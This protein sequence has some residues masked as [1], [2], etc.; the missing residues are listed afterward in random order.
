MRIRLEEYLKR[1]SDRHSKYGSV[2]ALFQNAWCNSPEDF[3]IKHREA[4][5]CKNVSKSLHLWIDLIFGFKQRGEAA[6]SADNVFHHLT[7]EGSVDL[8]AIVDP[9][10]RAS[11]EAQ[12]NEFGQ[13][14]QQLFREP[15][16]PR[17][18]ENSKVGKI[19]S[20]SDSV[21]GDVFQG[22]N[23]KF[24]LQIMAAIPFRTDSEIDVTSF[25]V[26][27]I[28]SPMPLSVIE[29]DNVTSIIEDFPFNQ[30]PSLA[31][32]STETGTEKLRLV[33]PY[34][35]RTDRRYDRMLSG[36]SECG[37]WDSW[38]PGSNFEMEYK[39]GASE[40]GEEFHLKKGVE[41]SSLMSRRLAAGNLAS[42]FMNIKIDDSARSSVREDGTRKSDNLY[43][44]H[45]STFKDQL[46][47]S[48]SLQLHRGPA[49][50]L[51]LSQEDFSKSPILYSAGQDGFVKVFSILENCQ[52]RATRL[53]IL[54]L[55]TLAL[56]RSGDKFPCWLAQMI[57]ACMHILLI[58]TGHWE[59]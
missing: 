40:T 30:G 14:P 27:A 10:Q 18:V 56:A 45:A 4:L 13:A 26:Q 52:I 9:I 49:T 25:N 17:L 41:S 47:L 53:G 23:P 48:H 51:I 42:S 57:I 15:H 59:G 22:L 21:Q 12:I 43:S 16:P 34:S 6:L 5:E 54:P 39:E 50:A 44:S 1:L 8:D 28:A 37:V 46:S 20:Y 3:I 36:Y 7:Y 35:A 31:G 2:I 11:L 33:R 29:E 38:S 24:L 55:S 32:V 58:M 19:T